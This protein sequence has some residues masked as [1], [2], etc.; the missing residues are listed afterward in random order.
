MTNK[1]SQPS[2]VSNTRKHWEDQGNGHLQ[3]NES[4]TSIW[5]LAISNIYFYFL[6]FIFFILYPPSSGIAPSVGT[7]G[8]VQTT[9]LDAALLSSSRAGADLG[10]TSDVEK[11][12]RPPLPHYFHFC[13]LV[14]YPPY[15]KFFIQS[16]STI[17]GLYQRWWVFVIVMAEKK[18]RC[19]RK[20]IHRFET[21]QDLD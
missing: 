11:C 2:E 10:R 17:Y 1:G 18:T 9:T 21:F 12:I 5:L 6:F 20:D 15:K 7:T 13:L 14:P 3:K 4:F 19:V 16:V 8:T